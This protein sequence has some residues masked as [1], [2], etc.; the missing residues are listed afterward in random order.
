MECDLCFSFF[1]TGALTFSVEESLVYLY[2]RPS[3]LTAN[4]RTGGEKTRPAARPSGYGSETK[5]RLLSCVRSRPA[6]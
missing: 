2:S 1:H 5:G 3:S 6:M 4:P